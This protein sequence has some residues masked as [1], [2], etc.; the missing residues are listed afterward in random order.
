MYLHGLF[1]SDGFRSAILSEM[2]NYS[3]QNP[4]NDGVE[5]TLDALADHLEKHIDVDKL[6]ALSEH[7]GGT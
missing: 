3:S 6:L 7:I 5:A 1:S 2:R 4:Y